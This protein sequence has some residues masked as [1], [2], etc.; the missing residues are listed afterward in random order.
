MA[1]K[2]KGRGGRVRTRLKKLKRTTEPY[3]RTHSVITCH[4]VPL[5]MSYTKGHSP[6]KQ[7]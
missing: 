1:G 6:L 4:G 7:T 5:T 2:S 3:V